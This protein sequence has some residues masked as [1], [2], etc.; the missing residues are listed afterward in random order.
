MTRSY[1]VDVGS[2]EIVPVE[3][4]TVAD[5]TGGAVEF[6]VVASGAT[7]NPQSWVAGSWGVWNATTSKVTAL[8]PTL[9]APGTFLPLTV[10]RYSLHVR[11]TVGSE[12]QIVKQVGLLTVLQ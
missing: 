3:I 4:T 8:S 6:G 7:G 10:G 2:V 12:D 1:S 9:P 11:W 5:P